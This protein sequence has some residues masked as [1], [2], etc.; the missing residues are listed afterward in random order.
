MWKQSEKQSGERRTERE[1]GRRAEETERRTERETERRATGRALRHRSS[2]FALLC[3][4]KLS[5]FTV[6]VQLCRVAY[7][8]DYYWGCDIVKPKQIP[9]CQ[10]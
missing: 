8:V 2:L 7:I 1:T 3:D 6:S 5:M 10:I 9:L 4:L